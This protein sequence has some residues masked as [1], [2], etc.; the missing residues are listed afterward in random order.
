MRGANAQS[1]HGKHYFRKRG[2]NVARKTNKIQR[3]LY[4]MKKIKMKTL[5]ITTANKLKK[6]WERQ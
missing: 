5:R 6:S 3:K 4:D 1:F 2:I